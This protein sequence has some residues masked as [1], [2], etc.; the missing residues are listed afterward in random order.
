MI[1]AFLMIVSFEPYLDTFKADG[2]YHI[3]LWYTSLDGE[4][5]YLNILGGI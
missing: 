3:I 1:L 4:R 5:N 2:R